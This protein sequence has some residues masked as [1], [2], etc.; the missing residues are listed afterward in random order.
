MMIITTI[1][2]PTVEGFGNV[3]KELPDQQCVSPGT[4]SIGTGGWDPAL[5]G[6]QRAAAMT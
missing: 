3:S 4:A 1:S 6:G 2:G 5:T